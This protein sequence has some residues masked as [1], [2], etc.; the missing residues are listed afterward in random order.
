MT[1][2]VPTTQWAQVFEKTAG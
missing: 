1:S 2:E